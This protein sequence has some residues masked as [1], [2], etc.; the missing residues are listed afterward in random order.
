MMRLGEL[1][2]KLS[3]Y[4]LLLAPILL[5]V[6]YRMAV[7]GRTPSRRALTLAILLLALFGGS[8][9]WMGIAQRLDPHERYVPASVG[10]DGEVT[11]GHG[12]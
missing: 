4:S 9:A 5:F 2:M 6:V 8:L 12:G 10:A 7:R 11:P 1:A 3:E